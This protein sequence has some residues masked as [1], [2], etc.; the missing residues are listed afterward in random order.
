M[1]KQKGKKELGK[2][3]IQALA[4][5]YN[6]V[7]G[8]DR[9]DFDYTIQYQELFSDSNKLISLDEY[10]EITDIKK[11]N[12]KYFILGNCGLYPFF[13]FRLECAK[14]QINRL[15]NMDISYSSDIGL[16]SKITGVRKLDIIV[17]SGIDYDEVETGENSYESIPYSYVQIQGTD[18]FLL[19][20]KL[21]DFYIKN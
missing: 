12:N 2:I 1:R 13:Y 17:G 8:W 5:K 10:V 19:T 11:V 4:D 21:V 15:I 6:A 18:D 3:E 9:L 14:P 16:I 20:G 7:K